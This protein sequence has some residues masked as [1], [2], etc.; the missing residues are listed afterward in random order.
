MKSIYSINGK[1][2]CKMLTSGFENL[3]FNKEYLDEINVFPVSD[4]DTGTNMTNTFG[5]GI[6]AMQATLSFNDTFSKFITG[7]SDGAR[8]NSGF[9]LSQ[10]FLGIYE[11]TK[12]KRTLNIA[13]LCFALTEAYKI[14]YEAVHMPIEGTMLTIMREGIERT[15]PKVN[16]KMSVNAFFDTLVNEMFICTQETINQMNVLR[17]NTV[18]DSGAVGLFL[19]FNGM[20][21]ALDNTSQVFDC[22]KSEILPKRNKTLVKNISFFRYCMQFVIK[23]REEKSR[24]YFINLLKR[25]GDSIIVTISEGVLSVHVHTNQSQKV[26]DEFAKFGNFTS[27][28][29]DDLFYSQEF[30]RLNQRKHDGFAV[31]VFTHGEGN[32]MTFEQLGADVAY[33]VPNEYS[34]S[35]DELKLL[36]DFFLT[37]NLIAFPNNNETFKR[38]KNIQWY[39]NYKNLYVVEADNLPKTFFN[40][41]SL[42]FDGGYANIIKSLDTMKKKRV[43]HTGVKSEIKNDYIQFVCSI[44]KKKFVEYGLFELLQIIDEDKTLKECSTIVVF[45]GK[46]PRQDDVKCICNYFNKKDLDFIYLNGRQPDYDFVIGAY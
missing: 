14:S 28:R 23:L 6:N 21:R 4:N 24:D 1:L 10:Y 8:G 45:G 46:S 5:S 39:S 15:L 41:S 26:I 33:C 44:G 20:K 38:L 37:E 16:D 18:L 32:A 11:C 9:I 30:K 34:I 13:D 7:I 40:L 19:I 27:S 12:H 17:E 43:F 36:L 2:L 3:S 22:K 35:E 31:I 25:R 42:M 29:V